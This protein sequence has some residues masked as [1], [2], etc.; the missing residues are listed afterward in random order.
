M[1][2]RLLLVHLREP[3]L[4]W[5]PLGG[6]YIAGGLTPKNLDLIKEVCDEITLDVVDSIVT[7]AHEGGR[8]SGLQRQV[9]VFWNQILS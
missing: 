1:R 5:I 4:K 3:T 8:I 9:C 6:L 7:E 2:L